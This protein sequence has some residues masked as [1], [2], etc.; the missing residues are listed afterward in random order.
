[1]LQL[2]QTEWPRVAHEDLIEEGVRFALDGLT[3]RSR[4]Q[5]S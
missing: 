5:A 2:F 4:E 3:G 1:M